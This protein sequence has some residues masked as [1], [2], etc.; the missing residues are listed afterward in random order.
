MVTHT[1]WAM[2]EGVSWEDGYADFDLD[3]FDDAAYIH[4]ALEVPAGDD[5]DNELRRQEGGVLADQ[6][7]VS[8]KEVDGR[9]G[10]VLRDL[11][12][13]RSPTTTKSQDP[14]QSSLSTLH[15]LTST[16][17]SFLRTHQYWTKKHDIERERLIRYLH[18]PFAL[19]GDGESSPT[20]TTATIVAKTDGRP[21]DSGS[22]SSS[23][24]G[25][26]SVSKQLRPKKPGWIFGGPEFLTP[27]SSP[28]SSEINFEPEWFDEFYD[29]VSFPEDQQNPA[30]PQRPA[31]KPLHR[32]SPTLTAVFPASRSVTMS[33]ITATFSNAPGEL[34]E[35]FFEA[36]ETEEMLRIDNAKL[37]GAEATVLKDFQEK[38]GVVKRARMKAGLRGEALQYMN[39]LAPD[40]RM[41]YDLA[42]KA[43]LRRFGQEKDSETSEERKER[44]QLEA[45]Q[46]MATLKQGNMSIKEYCLL[47]EDLSEVL[48]AGTLP[49]QL[50]KLWVDGLASPHDRATVLMAIKADNLSAD[51]SGVCK[52]AKEFLVLESR[53]VEPVMAAKALEKAQ[54]Q[55]PADVSQVLASLKELTQGIHGLGQQFTQAL[56]QQQVTRSFRPQHQ[57]AASDSSSQQFVGQTYGGQPVR[58]SLNGAPVPNSQKKC[59]NCQQMGHIS[60]DC[61]NAHVP[62]NGRRDQSAPPSQSRQPMTQAYVEIVDEDYMEPSTLT[63]AT[64]SNTIPVE[65]TRTSS[66]VPSTCGYDAYVV[67]LLDFPNRHSVN[68]VDVAQSLVAGAEPTP[69]RQM[70]HRTKAAKPLAVQDLLNK[71]DRPKPYDRPADKPTAPQS[72]PLFVPEAPSKRAVDG[73]D[74]VMLDDDPEEMTE[75]DTLASQLFRSRMQD[76]AFTKAL[77]DAAVEKLSAESAQMKAQLKATKK[78]GRGRQAPPI[79][80]LSPLS[81]E[82]DDGRLTAK[83]LLHKIKFTM[84][85]PGLPSNEALFTFGE[86]CD[87]CPRLRAQFNAAMRSSDP[88]K[89]GKHAEPEEQLAVIVTFLQTLIDTASELCADDET[90]TWLADEASIADCALFFT[91]GTIYVRATLKAHRIGAILIDC[92]ALINM[93]TMSIVLALGAK[94]D[95]E[96]VAGEMTYKMAAGTIH[97]LRYKWRTVMKIA[98]A[99]VKVT[100][101]VTETEAP[102]GILLSRKFMQQAKIR[103]DYERDH[104]TMGDV[105]GR[106]ILMPRYNPPLR[107]SLTSADIPVYVN[108]EPPAP[109]GGFA[110]PMDRDSH[111]VSHDQTRQLLLHATKA[112]MAKVANNEPILDISDEDD[113]FTQEESAP[114]S[115]ADIYAELES[116]KGWSRV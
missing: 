46:K 106:R 3:A 64:S 95:L 2:P 94:N 68:S 29:V 76:P 24:D 25:Y 73:P 99:H 17:D 114:V 112:L 100:L 23:E 55:T 84:H 102:Y 111:V 61:T 60:R 12:K 97:P 36:I 67:D 14:D 74:V 103:G 56:N 69:L 49:K 93:T 54:Q 1:A 78:P 71:P 89:R 70:Q 80:G 28:V 110:V 83:K 16:E 33:L 37:M 30:P 9:V 4:D 7:Q 116:G 48:T 98:C 21:E 86:L 107:R 39:T 10:D 18:N 52:A 87:A 77:I 43:L 108:C 27:L 79:Q 26:I 40:V 104:Y 90:D 32:P 47:L 57:R 22:S 58:Q 8:E 34:I 44:I 115:E 51:P 20:T 96:A 42:R 101:F 66:S 72:A 15:H 109:T 62:W 105:T 19:L 53:I 50:I 92:G 6:T 31:S 45:M 65:V 13:D 88:K 113:P 11:E 82:E 41:D 91:Y 38:G 81:S 35:E 85:H 59:F 63:P 5:C 75:Q